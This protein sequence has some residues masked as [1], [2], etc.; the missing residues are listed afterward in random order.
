AAQA[1]TQLAEAIGREEEAKKSLIKIKLFRRDSTENPI[2]WINE[3]ERAA[4]ANN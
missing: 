2:N 3:F 1:M 4:T